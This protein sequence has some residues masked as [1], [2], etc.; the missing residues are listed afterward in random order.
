MGLTWS[1]MQPFSTVHM[2]YVPTQA[3]VYKLLDCDTNTLL[4]IG[5]SSSLR[6][7]LNSHVRSNWAPYA[8]CFAYHVLPETILTYQRHE[9][10]SDLLGAYYGQTQCAPV[11]Q[12]VRGRG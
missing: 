5:Q 8:P 11:F 12:Y 7:R 9:L 1:L 3:G 6:G 4:Y 10:E 2:P